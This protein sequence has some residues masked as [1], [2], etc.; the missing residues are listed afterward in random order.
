[1]NVHTDLKVKI[2]F[3]LNEGA[4]ASGDHESF[5]MPGCN[6]MTDSLHEALCKLIHEHD[7]EALKWLEYHV[8]DVIHPDLSE[9]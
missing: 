5:M 1:M 8:V 3:E 6:N 2:G 4:D 9:D 7:M